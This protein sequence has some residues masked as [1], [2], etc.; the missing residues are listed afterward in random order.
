MTLET[1]RENIIKSCLNIAA[2]NKMTD[3]KQFT[4][5]TGFVDAEIDA[6]HKLFV[7]NAELNFKYTYISTVADQ[8]TYT[9]DSKLLRIDEVNLIENLGK[10]PLTKMLPGDKNQAMSMADEDNLPSFYDDFT[11]R[12][13]IRIHPTPRVSGNIVEVFGLYQTTDLLANTDVLIVPSKHFDTLRDYLINRIQ[14]LAGRFDQ[15]KL[16]GYEMLKALK[17]GFVAEAIG[18]KRERDFHNKDI[19]R[20]VEGS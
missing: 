8:F 20:F 9:L 11:V 19:P 1:L 15:T 10:Y 13:S 3:D 2:L 14:I 18:Y 7:E 5:E 4:L 6:A 12:G 17:K 16:N